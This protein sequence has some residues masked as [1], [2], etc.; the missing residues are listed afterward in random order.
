MN[1][2][3]K[4][5]FKQYDQHSTKNTPA[6][7]VRELDAFLK[8]DDSK[9]FIYDQLE[10]MTLNDLFGTNENKAQYAVILYLSDYRPAGHYVVMLNHGL[11]DNNYNLI[12]YFDPTGTGVDKPCE[13]LNIDPELKK[14]T[15]V[16]DMISRTEGNFTVIV[17]D[18][19]FQPLETMTCGKHAISRLL[20][21][22]TSL[23][24]YKQILTGNKYWTPDE[25]V[26]KM[27]RLRLDR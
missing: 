8:K 5:H 3:I 23:D 15:F 13:I 17:N 11:L 19:K 22:N 25:I 6:F 2:S 18:Y 21:F 4:R 12:E 20:A 9:V 27:I 16:Q 14:R 10:N 7:S 1:A 24:T 26:D